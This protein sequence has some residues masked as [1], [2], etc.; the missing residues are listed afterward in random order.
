LLSSEPTWSAAPST[1]THPLAPVPEL[2]GVTRLETAGAGSWA[3]TGAALPVYGNDTSS[4]V[5]VATVG[6]GR[7]VMLADASILQNSYLGTGDNAR[8]ALDV[9]GSSAR[10]VDFFES[11]HGYGPSMGYA[12][13]PG[14]WI[15]LLG[16]LVLAALALMVARGR[17]LG[18]PEAEGRDLP[19]PR[20]AYVDSVAG[21]LARARRPDEV[22]N[23]IRAETQARIARRAGLP[24][25]AAPEVLEAAARQAGLSEAEIGAMLG[26]SGDDDAVLSAGRALV[27]AGRT[28]ARRDE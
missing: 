24:V 20:R 19:P 11:Y 21:I 16:G 2:A 27:H 9:A 4:V 23:P 8:F 5:A 13:I 6:L 18:P 22:L 28:D 25:D 17:R 12:S 3:T 1:H 15:E 7:V 10:P 26:R 14:R